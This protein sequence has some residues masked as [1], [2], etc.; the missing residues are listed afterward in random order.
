VIYYFLFIF[1]IIAGFTDLVYKNNKRLQFYFFIFFGF[2]T[3]LLASIRWKTGTDWDSYV[4]IYSANN[5]FSGYMDAYYEKGFLFINYLSKL[6]Y[7]NYSFQLMFVVLFVVLFKYK[8]IYKLS[9]LPLI[10]LLASFSFYAGDLFT[11]RQGIAIAITLYSTIYIY[12]YNKITFF[13]LVALASSFHITAL[14]FLPAYYLYHLNISNKQL[15]Y[16]VFIS[17]LFSILIDF[18]EVLLSITQYLF[19]FI[20]NK[21]EI[22]LR[23]TEYSNLGDISTETRSIIGSIKRIFFFLIY[24]IIIK[25]SVQSDKFRGF[26]NLF[27]ISILIFIILNPIHPTF[28]RLSMYYSIYEILLI[29]YILLSFKKYSK[30]VIYTIVILYCFMKLEYGFNQH[31]ALFFPYETIFQSSFKQTY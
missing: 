11:V 21:I 19:P 9:P 31:R 2:I 5:T 20:G 3:I 14:F 24:I 25:K 30:L 1:F 8:A 23:M 13:L 10:S 16:L 29:P 4:R 27:V 7:D 22:Y 18:K 17:F 28:N 6:I 12:S 26:L 15:I